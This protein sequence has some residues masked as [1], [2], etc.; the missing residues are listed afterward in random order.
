MVL[1][2]PFSVLRHWRLNI[3][4]DSFLRYLAISIRRKEKVTASY[5]TA[6]CCR[7]VLL[8]VQE[9]GKE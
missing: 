3:I 8:C 6:V 2:L 5:F 4:F 7:G 9:K 1:R